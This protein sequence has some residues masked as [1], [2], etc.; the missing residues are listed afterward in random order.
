MSDRPGAHGKVKLPIIH[1]YAIPPCQI[2]DWPQAPAPSWA[3]IYLVELGSSQDQGLSDRHDVLGR[4][5]NPSFCPRIL[6]IAMPLLCQALALCTNVLCV[7]ICWESLLRRK[8]AS[9]PSRSD[10]AKLEE[11]RFLHSIGHTE[12]QSNIY[13][14]TCLFDC[15]VAG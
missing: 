11:W 15:S 7:D 2:P 4:A 12:V 3:L 13:R 8:H 1:P 9:K 10:S 5:R 14:L 6:L